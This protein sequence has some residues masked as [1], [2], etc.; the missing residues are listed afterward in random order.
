[1]KFVII[2][3]LILF[4]GFMI[5]Y[6]G[7]YLINPDMRGEDILSDHNIPYPAVI[8]HRGASI[9]APESTRPAYEIARETGA[10]YFEADVQMTADGEL[11]IFHDE[12]LERTSNVEEVFPDRINDEIGEFTLEELRQLDYGAGLMKLT[13]ITLMKTMRG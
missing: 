2:I 7:Y 5:F 9:V 11:I 1:M 6:G 10:D 8:A 3:L 4:A 12:T 13:K